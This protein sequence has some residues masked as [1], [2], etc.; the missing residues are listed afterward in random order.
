MENQSLENNRS[1]QDGCLQLESGRGYKE[2]TQKN[3]RKKSRRTKTAEPH[4][5]YEKRSACAG[6]LTE[7]SFR[8]NSLQQPT[9][10]HTHM[11]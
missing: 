6:V 8:F 2:N 4:P 3:K 5:V 1:S 9:H 7:S 11:H 10:T